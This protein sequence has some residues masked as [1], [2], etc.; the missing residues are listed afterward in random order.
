MLDRLQFLLN[1][2]RERLWVRPL[3]MAVLSVFAAFVAK[4]ADHVA[5]LQSVPEVSFDSLKTL[6]SVISSS[7][8]VI[9]TFSVASMVSAY[10]SAS[11]TATPRTFPLILADDVS[12]NA[13]STFIGAFIFSIVALVTLLNSYY[14]TAGR[15][16]LFVLTLAVFA[17]VILTFVRWVDRIARL[18]RLGTTVDKV[19]AAVQA[20]VNRRRK[21]PC[22]GGVPRSSAPGEEAGVAVFTD[23]IGYIQ[24]IDMEELQHC[25]RAHGLRVSI[26]AL[27]GTFMTPD[28]PLARVSADSDESDE[29]EKSDKPDQ[30]DEPKRPTVEDIERIRRAFVIGH[31][32]LF[33]D[34][35][36]FGIIVL[37]EIAS[38]ALSPAVNDPGT[39][40]DIIG[41]LVRLLMAWNEER[42]EDDD[43]GPE[44]DRI[45]VPPISVDDL[46]DDAFTGIARDGAGTI[47]VATRLQKAFRT[48]SSTD[49]ASLSSAAN[50]H[51]R[52]ALERAR[53]KMSLPADF[54]KLQQV[55]NG[56]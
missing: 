27:P 48:L 11:G 39:A 40:I 51:S 5:F 4:S 35:P 2:I 54:E 20:A 19:E 22:L 56:N 3:I 38:R 25:A 46:F 47:E 32:R 36:R 41:T 18:G 24:R 14:D 52:L 9:A 37:A 16:A 23:D 42:S 43:D 1:R 31:D 17:V 15:F 10:A 53:L 30:S 28:R 21:R 13:L 26:D 50:H 12:Q 29:A 44:Y 49:R 33:D 55:A 6:L 7:M 8:L 34:D 45:R